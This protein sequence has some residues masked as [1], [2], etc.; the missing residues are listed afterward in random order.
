MAV[1]FA[2]LILPGC[3]TETGDTNTGNDQDGNNTGGSDQGGNDQNGGNTGGNDQGGDN[4]GGTANTTLTI[5]NES[6][7]TLAD[8]KWNNAVISASIDLA[9]SKTENVAEGSGYLF[10]TKENASG[11]KCRTQDL[12]TV[13]KDSKDGTKVVITNNTVV[14]A[15]DDTSNVGPLGTIAPPAA[16]ATLAWSGAWTRVSDTKYTSNTIENNANTIER[17]DITASGA[18]TITIQITASS[19]GHDVGYASKLDTGVSTSDHQMGVSGTQ[20]STYVYTIPSGSHFLQF[21]YQKDYG[22]KSGSDNV[23]VEIVSSSFTFPT[24]NTKLKVQNASSVTLTDV[25]WGN[26]AVSASLAP[27]G[28]ET[29]EVSEGIGYLYFTKGSSG[30]F[31]CRTK[32]TIAVAKDE[33]KELVITDDTVVVAMDDTANEAPL[34]TIAPSATSAAMT[35]SGDWTR[36]SDTKYTSN[37]IGNS[38]NTIERLDI[39]ATVAGTVTIQITASSEYADYGYA[40]ELDTGVS[41]SDYQLRVSRTEVATHTYS[42]PAGNHWIQFMYEKDH[43]Y[44]SGNDRVTVEIISSTFTE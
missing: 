22:Y 17:L 41:T 4:T 11:L 38:A 3:P 14:V 42:I 37:T 13:S 29:V 2:A 9:Q 12:I 16:S 24:T 8:V 15:V 23:T 7:F 33:T 10:F 40:S 44:V 28:S 34:G 21:M 5:Q 25:K 27:A 36:V 6:S 35:W 39:A 43:S 20:V 18:G 30:D 26:T 1:L 19:E 31:K 32:E